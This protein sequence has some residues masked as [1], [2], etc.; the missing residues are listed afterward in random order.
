MFKKGEFFE[1]QED[2]YQKAHGQSANRHLPDLVRKY[3]L[4]GIVSYLGRDTL[5]A[6]YDVSTQKLFI[7]HFKA[8]G[9]FIGFIYNKSHQKIGSM[10]YQADGNKITVVI[11]DSYHI[12][13]SNTNTLYRKTLS[14]KTQPIDCFKNVCSYNNEARVQFTLKSLGNKN[15]NPVK[16][17]N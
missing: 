13:T 2:E 12:L 16:V 11:N 1:I 15:T 7:N 5:H 3:H 4:S 8:S 14:S 9:K 10:A 6:W 17:I